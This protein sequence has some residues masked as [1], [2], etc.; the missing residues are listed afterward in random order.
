MH[1]ILLS[2]ICSQNNSTI[3]I[4]FRFHILDNFHVLLT[5]MYPEMICL[6]SLSNVK[7]PW[8]FKKN[9]SVQGIFMEILAVVHIMKKITSFLRLVFK[10]ITS[11]T[12]VSSRLLY[13]LINHGRNFSQ[14]IISLINDTCHQKTACYFYKTS[15]ILC[16]LSC[17]C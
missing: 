15:K 2:I 4:P 10:Y 11:R 3:G 14:P 17:L 8:C 16:V 9:E 13:F 12:C 6:Y 7:I 5:F 1:R